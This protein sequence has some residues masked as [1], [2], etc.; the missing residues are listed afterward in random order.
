M[1]DNVC[2]ASRLERL[3]IQQAAEIL[4]ELPVVKPRW[5]LCDYISDVNEKY[6]MVSVRFLLALLPFITSR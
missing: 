1:H 5:N 2:G 4:R 3:R 6:N